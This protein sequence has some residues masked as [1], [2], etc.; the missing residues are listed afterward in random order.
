MKMS[1]R[2]GGGNIRTGAIYERRLYQD[3]FDISGEI[4]Q[5]YLDLFR[6]NLSFNYLATE[7]LLVNLGI[8]IVCSNGNGNAFST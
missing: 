6:E 8:I 7:N 4:L 1:S 5:K 2:F 3:R